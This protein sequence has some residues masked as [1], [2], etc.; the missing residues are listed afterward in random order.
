MEVRPRESW[1]GQNGHPSVPCVTRRWKYLYFETR[2]I[3]RVYSGAVTETP[4]SAGSSHPSHGR[5]H[6][7]GHAL[8]S[9]D[10]AFLRFQKTGNPDDLGTVFDETAA[11]L[12]Q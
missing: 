1:H 12:M 2:G 3:L 10:V 5:D 9:A 6:T 8:A 11:K 4:S 7:K